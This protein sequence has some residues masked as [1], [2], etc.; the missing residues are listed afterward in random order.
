MNLLQTANHGK[1]SVTTSDNID[2]IPDTS[3]RGNDY[4]TI[5]N[6]DGKFLTNSSI[7]VEVWPSGQKN[8]EKKLFSL[9]LKRNI[10]AVTLAK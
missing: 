1:V 3:F 6:N 7:R 4:F 2:Y 8:A 10:E 5:E 9:L